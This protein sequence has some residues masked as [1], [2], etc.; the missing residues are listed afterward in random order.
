MKK[1]DLLAFNEDSCLPLKVNEIGVVDDEA[2][3]RFP[4]NA[5]LPPKVHV[6]A[7]TSIL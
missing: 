6:S 3:L 2:R 5:V 1:G 7:M 4:C